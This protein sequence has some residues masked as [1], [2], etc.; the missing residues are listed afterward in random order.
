[1]FLAMLLSVTR[2]IAVSLP[3]YKVSK[4]AVIGSFVIYSSYMVIVSSVINLFAF[5]FEYKNE[6]S[7]CILGYTE[8]DVVAD[9]MWMVYSIEHLIITGVPPILA[10]ISFV[11]CTLN[12]RKASVSAASQEHNNRASTTIAMFTGLFLICNLPY[13][14][15]YTGRCLMILWSEPYPGRMFSKIFMYWYSWPVAKILFTGLNAALNPVLYYC[16]MTDFKL[17]ISKLV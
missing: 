11:V 2:A 9:I 16:R 15:I 14:V 5:S 1:M 8:R 12:L 10:F 6:A 13:F 17:W 7:Y 4:S 3:F